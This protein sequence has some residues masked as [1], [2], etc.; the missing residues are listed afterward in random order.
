MGPSR[1]HGEAW[2]ARG[3]GQPCYPWLSLW[4]VLRHIRVIAD[5]NHHIRNALQPIV[6]LPYMKEQ[7]EQIRI[8]QEGTDRIQWAL[9]EILPGEGEE[10]PRRKGSSAAA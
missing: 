3:W 8:I 7:A 4:W 10:V 5:M 9:R 1:S 2:Q 6:Y